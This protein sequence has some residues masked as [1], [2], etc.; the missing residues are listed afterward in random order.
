MNRLDRC[1]AALRQA[2]R[3]GL[4]TY[5]TAGDPDFATSVALLARLGSSGADI[6]ELGMPF[7]DP[8]ADGP[9][10][11]QAHQRALANGQTMAKTLAMVAQLRKSDAQTPV[12]LMGY[13]NPV[14]Q[15]GVDLFM[16]EAAQ[17]GVDGLLLVDLPF[18]H[19]ADLRTLAKEH[20]IALIPM[21]AP[22]SDEARLARILKEAAGFIYHVSINGITGGSSRSAD[23]LA[24]AVARIRRHST[25][26]VALGFGIRSEAQ[27]A[28]LREVA[29]LLVVGSALVQT[30]SEEGIEALCQR[31]S[32]M[33]SALVC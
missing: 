32:S 17:S 6:I 2:G 24:P 27:L 9:V 33:A 4:V 30:L 3:P 19:A 23:E 21:T 16:Q 15:Y 8:V 25:L 13:L 1:L 11:Q 10:I 26:P 28:E 22:G 12:V 31:V 18:E 20:G 7:S 14:M 29:D 5:V